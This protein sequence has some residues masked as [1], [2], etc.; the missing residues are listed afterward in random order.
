MLFLQENKSTKLFD[1]YFVEK[2]GH[3]SPLDVQK[4]FPFERKQL[5]QKAALFASCGQN[6]TESKKWKHLSKKQWQHD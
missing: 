6:D 1:G 5:F 3:P 4:L 2:E